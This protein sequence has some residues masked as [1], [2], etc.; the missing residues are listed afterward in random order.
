MLTTPRGPRFIFPYRL[1]SQFPG[2][3]SEVVVACMYTTGDD[4]IAP[5]DV[6]FF[7]KNMQP[8]GDERTLVHTNQPVVVATASTDHII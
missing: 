4:M 6:Q 1:V 8:I 2:L 7:D 3:A 5:R